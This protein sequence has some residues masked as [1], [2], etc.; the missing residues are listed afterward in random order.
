MKGTIVNIYLNSPLKGATVKT[1]TFATVTNTNGVFEIPM[2]IIPPYSSSS[3]PNI[4]S[5]TL[6]E[7]QALEVTPYKGDGEIKEDLGVIGL[8]PIVASLEGDKIDAS[9]IQQSQIE[10][11]SASKRDF[12]YFAQKKLVDLINNV[13]IVLIPLILTLI[14]RFGIT[15]ANKLIEEGKTKAADILDQITCPT[16]E[17]LNR[18]ISRKNK[19][20]KQLNNAI[21]TIDITTKALGITGGIITA[22]EIAFTILKN[23]PIPSAVPPGIGLPINVIL[24]IQD[25]KDRIDKLITSLKTA[26]AGLLVILVLLRQVL[27]QAVQYLNLLDSLVQ[28]C[29]PDANQE[30]L[31]AE[32]TALTQQQTQQ[33]SPVVINVN[34]FE[35]GVETETTTNSLKRRRAIARNKQ[36]VVMLKGEWSFSSIDQILIDELVFYIQQNDLKAE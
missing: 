31:S 11:I 19:T 17:E 21:K 35:M 9:Q 24:G 4:I 12:K 25:G 34:G 27:T 18:I 30:Q 7:Y 1:G 3:S 15:K 20:V 2:D 13:K 23:L 10:E 32:L 22:L 5:I 8:T 14:A 16:P 6:P 28:H 33:L 26:N 36:G 29:Y